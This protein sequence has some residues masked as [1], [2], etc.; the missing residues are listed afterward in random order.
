MQKKNQ[1]LLLAPIL[2]SCAVA[3]SARGS[4]SAAQPPNAPAP[5]QAQP[6]DAASSAEASAAHLTADHATIAVADMDKETKWYADVLGFRKRGCNQSAPG[7]PPFLQHPAMV[8]GMSNGSFAIDLIQEPGSARH[9]KESDYLEEGWTDL[10]FFD[11]SFNDTYKRLSDLGVRMRADK[12]GK[13][14]V[15]HI[16]IWDPEGNQIAIASFSEARPMR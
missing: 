10:C 15:N 11:S 14:E 5:S 7:R 9:R 1:P 2:F 3:L 13:G 4:A 16:L 8:C 6:A 12:N